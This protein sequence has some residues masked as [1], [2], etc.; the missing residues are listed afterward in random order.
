MYLLYDHDTRLV[1]FASSFLEETTTTTTL[2]AAKF[3]LHI[4]PFNR[5]RRHPTLFTLPSTAEPC[6]CYL[7]TTS[8]TELRRVKESQGDTTV[9]TP[10]AGIIPELTSAPAATASKWEEYVSRL[11]EWEKEII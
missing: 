3:N 2:R 6:N 1:L 7:R 9:F 11:Q 4:M 5:N 10:L 8:K